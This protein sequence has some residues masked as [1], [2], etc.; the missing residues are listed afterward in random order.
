VVL[1]TETVY[2][3]AALLTQ[4]GGLEKLRQ[5]RGP[6]VT[7]K[8]FT[9]HLAHRDQALDYI[10]PANSF[11]RR[12]M[13]KLWPGPVGIVFQVSPERR[14]EVAARLNLPETAIY[15]GKR[16]DAALP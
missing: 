12:L 16:S 14:K 15:D 7:D 2:G 8:P 6:T 1:P 13:R 5:L 11:A 10:D 3:A 4:S 9:I